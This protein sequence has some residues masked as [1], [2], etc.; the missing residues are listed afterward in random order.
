MAGKTDCEGIPSVINLE[1]VWPSSW[2]HKL[3][4]GDI[5]RYWKQ[6]GL[7]NASYFFTMVFKVRMDTCAYIAQRL[8]K[9]Q[10]LPKEELVRPLE[11]SGSWKVP[12]R[13]APGRVTK[14]AA[15]YLPAR[16]KIKRVA[17]TLFDSEKRVIT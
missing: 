1:H 2:T 4:I 13:E 7:D 5:L 12:W 15:Y 6:L 9:L 3:G 14:K 17:A 11:S 8:W 16:N 10:R